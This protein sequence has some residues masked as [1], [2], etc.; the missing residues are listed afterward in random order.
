MSECPQTVSAEPP[1]DAAHSEH[2]DYGL[3]ASTTVA[4]DSEGTLQFQ[5]EAADVAV[6]AVPSDQ[7]TMMSTMT[8]IGPDTVPDSGEPPT[9]E[10]L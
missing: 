2:S 8:G 5:P 6:P 1:T 4:D 10:I 3:Q 7:P 9:S